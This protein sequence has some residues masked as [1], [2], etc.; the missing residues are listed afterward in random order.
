MAFF[1]TI[2]ETQTYFQITNTCNKYP[3]KK[4]S[5]DQLTVLG[6]VLPI[7]IFYNA[8]AEIFF[9][10][11]EQMIVVSLVASYGKYP[12]HQNHHQKCLLAINW[13]NYFF[14]I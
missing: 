10:V 3:L 13:L 5:F 2:W 6:I 14:P 12:D 11:V 1:K 4:I 7:F 8:L 9:T